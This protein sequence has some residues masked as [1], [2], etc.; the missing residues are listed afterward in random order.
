VDK[1]VD[2]AIRLLERSAK[3]GYTGLV[4]ADYKFNILDRM[5]ERYVKNVER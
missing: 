2:D 5:P 4:L 1:N 3:A